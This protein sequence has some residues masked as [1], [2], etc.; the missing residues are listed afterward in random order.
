MRGVGLGIIYAGAVRPSL[1]KTYLQQAEDAMDFSWSKYSYGKSISYSYYHGVGGFFNSRCLRCFRCCVPNRI[2]SVVP[3]VFLYVFSVYLYVNTFE[4]YAFNRTG[5]KKLEDISNGSNQSV[6]ARR[7]VTARELDT[8][9][10]YGNKTTDHVQSDVALL[11]LYVGLANQIPGI[12]SAIILGP[13]SDRYGRKIAMGVVTV[14]L[15]LQ[16]LVT[17]VIFEFNLSLKFFILSSGLRAL[18]GGLPGFLTTS[19]S[20]IADISSRKWL[21]LRLGILEAVTFIASSLGLGISCTWIQVKNC[22]FTPISWLMLASSV[23]LVLYLTFFVRE[24]LNRRQTIQRRLLL[25]PGPKSLLVGFKI[26]FSRSRGIPLWK[27]WL[28]MAVLCIAVINQVGT[29][30]IVTLFLLHEPLEWNPGIIGAYLAG[31][32]L[33]RGL[34][35]IIILPV[36]VACRLRD[37]SIALLGVSIACLTNIGIG[38]VTHTWQMFVGKTSLKRMLY[39]YSGTSLI[40]T[41]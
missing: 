37:S 16:S 26:F 15:V 18:T 36:L 4:L 23:A 21:T 40:R 31:N 30:T 6:H 32:E 24:S 9:G 14:G 28:S 3:A 13:F 2:I 35:L 12:I 19:Y 22:Y 27:L 20:Y 1:Q 33:I 39:V 8:N 41:P 29:L 17:N 25:T 11:N 10:T 38:F 34:S 5:S 7:C